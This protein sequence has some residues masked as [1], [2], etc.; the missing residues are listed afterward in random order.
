MGVSRQEYYK[1]LTIK[2]EIFAVS[3]TFLLLFLRKGENRLENK[4]LAPVGRAWQMMVLRVS[5]TELSGSC[6]PDRGAALL[7]HLTQEKPFLKFFLFSNGIFL[8]FTLEPHHSLKV[9]LPPN[10]VDSRD[11]HSSF[12]ARA[13]WCHGPLILVSG[14]S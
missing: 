10:M 11:L 14:S 2:F 3:F 4:L 1:F 13:L 6:D 8:S 5:I 12:L 7:I 9:L